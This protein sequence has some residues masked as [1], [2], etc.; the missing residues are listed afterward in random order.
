MSVIT[1]SPSGQNISVSQS[2]TGGIVTLTE[3]DVDFATITINQGQQ[4]PAGVSA[5]TNI[6]NYGNDRIVTSLGTSSGL[7]AE[8]NLTFDGNI[9]RVNNIPVSLSGHTHI[10]SDISGI[11]GSISSGI[12]SYLSTLSTISNHCD[13]EYVLIQNSGKNTQLVN[14]SNLAESISTIDGGGVLYSGC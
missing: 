8:S 2:G 10:L 5:I 1:I 9:L 11:S 3:S 4:G 14:I 13:I 12:S 7:Y 6:D